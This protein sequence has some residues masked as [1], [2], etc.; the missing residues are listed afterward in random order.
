MSHAGMII[1]IPGLEVV[2]VKSKR[3]IDVWA[4]PVLQEPIIVG[5]DFSSCSA[6]RA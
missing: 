1:G 3:C 4:S 5:I 6:A 2:R